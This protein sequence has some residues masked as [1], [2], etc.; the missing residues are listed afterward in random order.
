[1]ATPPKQLI[2]GKIGLKIYGVGKSKLISCPQ[3]GRRY[4]VWA[5]EDGRETLK[6]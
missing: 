1:V 6:Y 2:P 5:K 4:Q 3:N